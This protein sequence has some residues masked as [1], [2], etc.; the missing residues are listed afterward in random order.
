MIFSYQSGLLADDTDTF[1]R[2]T[3][4]QLPTP[5]PTPT[6]P[7]DVVAPPLHWKE[8]PSNVVITEPYRNT[9][10]LPSPERVIDYNATYER[11]RQRL[12]NELLQLQTALATQNN[13][14]AQQKQVAQ[15]QLETLTKRLND[16]SASSAD[17]ESKLQ[18]AQNVQ[19]YVFIGVSVFL[20]LLLLKGR[21]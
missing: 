3:R 13:L 5:T 4:L 7:Q 15:T 20:T 19:N 12:E 2:G 6:P 16:L 18:N 9:M 10:P 21:K 14:S 17:L 8:M 11:E 1:V